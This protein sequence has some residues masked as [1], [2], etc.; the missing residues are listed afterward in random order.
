MCGEIIYSASGAPSPRGIWGCA[1]GAQGWWLHTQPE[2][3]CVSPQLV[4]N[5]SCASE[6][7]RRIDFSGS[8]GCQGARARRGSFMGSCSLGVP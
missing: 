6:S 1:P 8:W 2:Y 4:G 5:Q 7:D 3:L